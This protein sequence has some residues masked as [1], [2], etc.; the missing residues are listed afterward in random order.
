MSASEHSCKSTMAGTGPRML[1]AARHFCRDTSAAVASTYALA[2]FVLVGMAGVAWDWTRMTALD[3]ELQNAADQAALAAATQ[4]DGATGAIDRA[5]QAASGLVANITVLANDGD[6][7]ALA[8]AETGGLVF[9]DGYNQVADT[10]GAVTTD[11]AAARVVTV[12]IEPREA[13]FAMTPVVGVLRSGQISAQATAS[14]G[15]AICNTPPVMLC[16]PLEEDGEDFDPADYIGHGLRLISDDSSAP[17]NFGFLANGIG[18]GAQELASALG[19]DLVPGNCVAT[20]GVTT[21]PGLKD[22]VFN[23]LNTRFDIDINGANTCPDGSGNCTAAPM[24]RKDL[25]KANLNQTSQCS[26]G[27]GNNWQQPPAAG[28]YAPTGPALLTPTE[29]SAVTVMGYPRDLCHAWSEAGSCTTDSF[30][31]I[32]TGAWDRDA[33]FQANYGWDRATWQAVPEL[34]N[35][36]TRFEVYEWE[37]AR[38]LAG[39]MT[40]AQIIKTVGGQSSSTKPVCRAE[41]NASRRKITAAVINCQ[42]EG[43][44]GRTSGVKVSAWVELFL[45]EPSTTRRRAGPS[46][47]KMTDANDVYV[48]VIR[49]VDVGGDGANGDVVRRDVPFL[50]R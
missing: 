21:E 8:V 35:T 45:I 26:I 13:F 31:V 12:T 1:D 29:R 43:V 40:N 33:F 37:T 49:S 2:M 32:G 19:H 34:S 36:P 48:E 4:L 42:A 39:T 3:S 18:T 46:S 38:Y 25:V 50:I 20:D 41:G 10:F 15:S 7:S 30:G 23:A 28:R 5:T 16:N 22:V 27:N 24:S 6:G 17:G 11:D 14:L 47:E 9:Y 44:S